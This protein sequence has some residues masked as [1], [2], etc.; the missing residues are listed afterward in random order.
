[1]PFGLSSPLPPIGNSTHRTMK[2]LLAFTLALFTGLSAFA[3]AALDLPLQQRNAG[4]TGFD[5]RLVSPVAS[6]VFTFSSG[7][8]PESIT[9]SALLDRIGSTRGSIMYRGASG[10]S[11]LTPGA[12]GTLLSSNGVGADPSYISLAGTSAANPT[13][14]L[15]LTAVNGVA[16]TFMRSHAAP[17]LDQTIAPTMTG[18][19][20][21]TNATASSSTN[22]TTDVAAASVPAR[23]RRG[24]SAG[25]LIP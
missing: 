9:L 1:M 10:W 3:D 19:W 7:K 22:V 6:G 2:K 13:A 5:K 16:T 11:I 4:N 25:L 14:S 23:Q 17:A 24:S 15:G 12:S 8:L 21:F 20:S 18:A